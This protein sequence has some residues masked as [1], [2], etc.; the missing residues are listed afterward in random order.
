[1]ARRVGG[2][3]GSRSFRAQWSIPPHGGNASH[4]EARWLT[5][6]GMGKRVP[7]RRTAAQVTLG[8]V[9]SRGPCALLGGP[10]RLAEN[11]G[12]KCGRHRGAAARGD[13]ML[14]L[15][16]APLHRAAAC[17]RPGGGPAWSGAMVVVGSG[18]S[19]RPV[20]G[21]QCRRC[22]ERKADGGLGRGALEE[23]AWGWGGRCPG[24]GREEESV[25]QTEGEPLVQDQGVWDLQARRGAMGRMQA[26]VSCTPSHIRSV[27]GLSSCL[28]S[29]GAP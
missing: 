4:Q 9:W 29:L 11:T 24:L 21:L 27:P 26:R 14:R 18:R 17:G 3:R 22:S 10:R 2:L 12:F 25:T 19:S 15:L 23:R 13:P 1:M 5:E 6:P 16:K 8:E 7:G 28:S 20:R